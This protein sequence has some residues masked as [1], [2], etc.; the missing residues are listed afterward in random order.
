[1][2]PT[3]LVQVGREA[4]GEFLLKTF[5]ILGQKFWN[6]SFLEVLAGIIIMTLH[7]RKIVQLKLLIDVPDFIELPLP[8]PD[9]EF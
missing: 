8:R 2:I 6:T 7:H 1:M 5:Q 4:L 9:F 3:E